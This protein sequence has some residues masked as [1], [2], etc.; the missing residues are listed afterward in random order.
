[1]PQ[2][3]IT[4]EHVSAIVGEYEKTITSLNTRLG[5]LRASLLDVERE[6]ESLR[7][8]LAEAEQGGTKKE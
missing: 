4:P 8:R 3:P 1:M 7:E 6:A 2:Q 5:N